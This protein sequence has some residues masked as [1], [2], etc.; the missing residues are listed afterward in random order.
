M[1]T[2]EILALIQAHHWWGISLSCRTLSSNIRI[3]RVSSTV[4]PLLALLFLRL[5]SL[6]YG[7]IRT[8]PSLRGKVHLTAL[9]YNA[10]IIEKTAPPNISHT[11]GKP[12]VS[13]E[14]ESRDHG[15]H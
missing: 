8:F 9:E 5:C 3:F 4:S 10:N 14:Q 13:D 6:V 15:L 2:I 7:F 11:H 1:L 12:E